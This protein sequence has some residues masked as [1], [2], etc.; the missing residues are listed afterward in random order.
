MM[1]SRLRPGVFHAALCFVVA[2]GCAADPEL[3]GLARSSRPIIQGDALNPE[4]SGT[5]MVV[6]TGGCSG[7][8]L[9][10][11]WVLTAAHCGLDVN[12]PA[13]ITVQMGSQSSVAAYAV[14][15]PSLDF[16]LA[17]LA[18]PFHMGGSTTGYR[19]PI[20]TGTT[21]SLVGQTLV[22]RGYGCNAYTST[23]GSDC[24]GYGTLRQAL[25]SV[26]SAGD[27]YNYNIGINARG[28]VLAPGDSGTGCFISTSQGLAL[29]GVLKAGTRTENYLGRP[30]N[31][32]DWAA[33]YVNGTAIP[34]PDH[35]YAASTSHP[36]F[37][38]RPLPNSYSN[39]YAW[40]PCPGGHEY[41]F[42]PTYNMETGNDFLYITSNGVTYPLTGSATATYTGRGSISVRIAT[43]G[44][45]QSQGLLAMP[46]QCADLTP[47][48]PLWRAIPG[49]SMRQL[50]VA[51]NTDGTLETFA[52]DTASSN[53]YDARQLAP[54][55]AWGAWSPLASLGAQSLAVARNA[56]GRLEV[57]V[58]ATDRSVRHMWRWS[59]GTWSAWSSLGRSDVAQ[60]ATGS[61]G[62]GVISA[63]ALTTSGAVFR[64]AQS[65][66]NGG[67]AGAWEAL[68]GSAITQIAVGNNADGRLEVFAVGGDRVLYHQW[69]QTN[70]VWSG[71]YSLGRTDVVQ[72]AVANEADGTLA[73]YVRTTAGA[74]FRTAQSGPNLGWGGAWSSLGGTLLQNISAAR[75]TNGR[76]RVLA[77]GG[78]GQ[79]YIN[80][81]ATSGGAFTGWAY[82]GVGAFRTL[83][84]QASNDG[85][86]EVFGL[87]VNGSVSHLAR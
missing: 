52:I 16:A 87:Q 36:T 11:A 3:D 69:Q 6:T 48:V 15:H 46:I 21:A 18:T 82:L 27:D 19:V 55:G 9:T 57:F 53:V 14:V 61:D 72:V 85:H 13:S 32:R 81:E 73:A 67:W 23:S 29:A 51:K 42:S 79:A 68:G 5:V 70:G 44:T 78:S 80:E 12:N 17:R 45:V 74:V 64:T 40:E 56:D 24:S 41:S 33:A 35:W 7:T 49:S 34:L 50:A 26:T 75:A 2:A 4:E 71:W 39:E 60:V 1:S 54:D 84:H 58:V 38:D 83:T 25:M 22:C 65:G 20:Y 76:V 63:F 66:A 10:N 59:N 43:N 47:S 77:V 28:Q 8:L 31:W 37:L 62:A 86:S 30:E